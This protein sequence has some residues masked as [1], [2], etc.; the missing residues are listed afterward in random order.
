MASSLHTR[1][2]AEM[3][4]GKERKISALIPHA[5]SRY[6]ALN[7][8]VISELPNDFAYLHSR[9]VD[10]ASEH[11]LSVD[12]VSEHPLSVDC[13]SEHPAR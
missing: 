6:I 3:S 4:P 2:A 8:Q 10:C 12:R 7:N 9:I 13:A 1:K 5:H 11:P